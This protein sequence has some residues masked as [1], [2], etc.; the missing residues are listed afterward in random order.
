[1]IAS[2]IAAYATGSV[3]NRSAVVAIFSA[4]DPTIVTVPASIASGRSVTS[5]VNNTGF[6]KLGASSWIP[7]LSVITSHERSISVTKAG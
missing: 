1:L 7:P 2:A 3:S 4:S 5:R 6:P